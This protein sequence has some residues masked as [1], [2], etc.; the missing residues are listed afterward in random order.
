MEGQTS[1]FG[2]NVIQLDAVVEELP[3]Y[4]YHSE[5][6]LLTPADANVFKI[7]NLGPNVLLSRSGFTFPPTKENK[8]LS[9]KALPDPV[10]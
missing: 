3:P 6:L 2:C 10:I 1:S 9:A 7:I 8:I 5:G 4:A